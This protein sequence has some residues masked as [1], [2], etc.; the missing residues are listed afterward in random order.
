[1]HG[2]IDIP[3]TILA[4][5]TMEHISIGTKCKVSM[6]RKD[7]SLVFVLFGSWWC[8]FQK[9]FLDICICGKK[10]QLEIDGFG[11]TEYATTRNVT[12]E[13]LTLSDCVKVQNVWWYRDG[14]IEM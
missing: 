3:F 14:F 7:H 1:M 8:S 12:C 11:F 5:M 2:R 4:L 9:L 10:T 6:K 13:V